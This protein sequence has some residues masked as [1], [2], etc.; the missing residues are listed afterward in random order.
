MSGDLFSRD[1]DGMF[2]YRGRADDL[3][4]VGGIWVAPAE[5]EACL[6]GHPAVVDVAVVGYH[7]DGLQRPRAFV[8][9]APSASPGEELAATLKAHVR[10]TLS[11]HKYP[12]DLRFVAELPKTGS[13]KVD[14]RALREAV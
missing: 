6:L 9:T 5:I 11:P 4:K 13:G 10:S 12:R 1:A 7:E 3:L 14:R 8:V 2:A